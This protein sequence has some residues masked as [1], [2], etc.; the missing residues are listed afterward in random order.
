MFHTRQVFNDLV[1]PLHSLNEN[2]SVDRVGHSDR[3]RP[4]PGMSF[5]GVL[6]R[7]SQ[8]HLNITRFERVED[9]PTTLVGHLFAREIDVRRG[10]T[11]LLDNLTPLRNVLLGKQLFEIIERILLSGNARGL[12]VLDGCF[13][14]L[15]QVL[16]LSW[17]ELLDS[18]FLRVNKGRS[19]LINFA[20]FAILHDGFVGSNELDDGLRPTFD[21][22][23]EALRDVVGDQDFHSIL[24][25]LF[26]C[27]KITLYHEPHRRQF[28]H[29]EWV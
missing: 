22:E 17:I 18:I 5:C 9:V 7:H 11:L 4:V 25:F 27:V 6:R 13:L 16:I 23:L 12:E 1:R 3:G 24:A 29:L 21:E 15:D 8:H 10:I 26:R 28:V 20:K 19:A 14:F 2:V